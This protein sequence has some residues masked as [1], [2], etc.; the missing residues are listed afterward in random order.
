MQNG[1]KHAPEDEIFVIKQAPQNIV[2]PQMFFAL[3]KSSLQ[4][5]QKPN[6]FAAQNLCLFL[7][8]GENKV[9]SYSDQL[10]LGQVLKIGFEFDNIVT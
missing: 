8:Q 3:T 4:L 9:N 2:G 5:F 7:W 6:C 10:K 1:I